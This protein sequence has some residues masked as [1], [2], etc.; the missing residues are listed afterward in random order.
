MIEAGAKFFRQFKAAPTSANWWQEAIKGFRNESLPGV[1]GLYPSFERLREVGGWRG[2]RDFWL[3]VK[4]AHPELGIHTDMSDM[5]W[6][7]I[8]DWFIV[9]SVGLLP[10]AEVVSIMEESGCGRTDAAIKRRLYDLGVNTY[11]RWGWTISRVERVLG[12]SGE[13]IR[14]HLAH[15]LLP[16]YRSH[17]CIYIDPAD[18]LVIEEYNWKKKRHPPELDK[19]VRASLMLRL[20]YALLGYDW[21]RY[22]LHRARPEHEFYAARAAATKHRALP[23]LPRPRPNKIQVG[24]WVTINEWWRFRTPGARE[25]KGEVKAV[26]WS[27]RTVPATQKSPE[28]RPCWMAKVELPKLRAHGR[29]EYRRVIYQV[30]LEHL[31][32]VRKPRAKKTPAVVHLG[33]RGPLR[34]LTGLTF[35][36]LTVVRQVE[37]SPRGYR[38]WLCDCSCG[39]QAVVRTSYLTGGKTE[40]CGCAW[41]EAWR[42]RNARKFVNL[43]GRRFG[44]LKV[45]G[46]S[47]VR[48]KVMQWFV[49]CDCGKEKTCDGHALKQGLTRSCGCLQRERASAARKK[50]AKTALRK[51]G[52]FAATVLTRAAT[53]EEL[54]QEYGCNKCG[55]IKQLSEMV[56]VF[57]RKE[58]EYRLRPR[59]KKCHN[60]SERGHRREWKRDYLRRWRAR[61]AEKNR[62]YWKDRPDYLDRSRASSA[63]YN[64]RHR[65]ALAIRR[66]LKGNGVEVSVAE[67][68][69]LL[70]KFG[71]AY[72]TRSGLTPE[73][74][75]R[76]EH[77]RSEQRRAGREGRLSPFE[78]RIKVYDE[79]LFIEPGSQ[80]RP[81]RRRGENLRN[82]RRGAKANAPAEAAA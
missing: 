61:N 76:C 20:C 31:T 77:I 69:E 50:A 23:A 21:R 39:K 38:Q 72:P 3:D 59:C 63:R 68:E 34:D 56:V 43:T 36:R 37:S 54:P 17:K 41:D 32:R 13:T 65:D 45:L 58:K 71:L 44:R 33:R 82:F 62:G 80:T 10:R 11:N 53:L 8:E 24:H 64:E 35:G 48:G 29:P 9:E 73:G 47:H 5:P 57:S 19:A 78:I 2:M 74:L 26:Y 25:R 28:R 18:L 49:K 67:A 42:G 4:Q 66:R 15:G 12:V 75:R 6:R 51:K 79:G 60:E 81:Y 1:V 7:P 27:G 52:R 14:K 16:Y 70:K 30:P 22:A 46:P 40:S 55:E